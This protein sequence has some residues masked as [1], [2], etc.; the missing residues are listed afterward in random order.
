MINM[1]VCCGQGERMMVGL[2]FAIFLALES[3]E[4]IGD[5]LFVMWYFYLVATAPGVLVKHK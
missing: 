3:L 4:I 1:D 5:L 2:C